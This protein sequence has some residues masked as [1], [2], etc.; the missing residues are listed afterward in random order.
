MPFVQ[1]F[2][3]AHSN[4]PPVLQIRDPAEAL[5]PTLSELS[6]FYDTHVQILPE[7]SRRLVCDLSNNN[8]SLEH[9]KAFASWLQQPSNHVKIYALDLSFNRIQAASWDV[10]VPLVKKLSVYTLHMDFGG[11]YLPPMLKTEKSLKSLTNTISL[12]V[13]YHSQ[14]G[15]PWV[16]S[17]TQKS[18]NFK[19]LAYGS[20]QLKWYERCV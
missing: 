13:T 19:E 15:D 6:T 16:D 10:F 1:T 2:R 12:A 4:L 9:L 17:W 5:I 14:S 20:S 11:N 3:R 8:F 18:R 7:P